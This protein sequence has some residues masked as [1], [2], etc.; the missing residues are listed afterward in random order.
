MLLDPTL[1][2]VGQP[3]L[4]VIAE[5]HVF[6]LVTYF[7]VQ[8]TIGIQLAQQR[9]EVGKRLG[10]LPQADFQFGGFHAKSGFLIRIACILSQLLE[11]WQRL[12]ELSFLGQGRGDLLLHAAIVGEKLFQPR[13][14]G[15]GLV[16]ALRPL[17]DATEGLK[18]VEQVVAWRFAGDGAFEGFG[19]GVGLSDH[20]ECL[21]EVVGGQGVVRQTFFGLAEGGDG[22]GVF[23]ALRF[24]QSDDHRGDAV[25]LVFVGALAIVAEELFETAAFDVIAVD[26]IERGAASGIFLQDGEEALDDL[27]FALLLGSQCRLVLGFGCLAEGG[28]EKACQQDHESES[29]CRLAVPCHD[30]FPSECACA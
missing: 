21:A 23:A 26:A 22:F 8:P 6:D 19:G 5:E 9:L 25:A 4:I 28:K 1:V 3:G 10:R 12:L 27:C 7:A 13:P 2:V 16:A 14:D 11:A 17:V 24:E 18:D 15:Q 20:D 29:R 30:A